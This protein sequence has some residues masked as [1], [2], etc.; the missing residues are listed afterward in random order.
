LNTAV[1]SWHENV[2]TP[3]TDV[4]YSDD[5]L[6]NFPGHTVTDLYIWLSKFW[7]DLKREYGYYP[8]ENAAKAFAR[9]NGSNGTFPLRR[10][11]ET[12]QNRI[13]SLL[14][15]SFKGLVEKIKG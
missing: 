15:T 9:E 3:I 5:L 1:K 4:I 10:T 11:L 2:Y 13:V 7:D 14:Q 6:V 8:L 12:T